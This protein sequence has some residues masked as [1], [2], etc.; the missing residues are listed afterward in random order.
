MKK[1]LY[2]ACVF[3]TGILVSCNKSE[4]G[5]SDAS[6]NKTITLKVIA[7]GGVQTRSGTS[8]DRFVIEVYSDNTYT[9]AANAFS[10]GTNKATNAT[11]EFSVILDLSKDYYCL[12]WADKNAST[13]YTVTDLKAV[14]VK[15]G[16]V[17]TEAWHG[18]LKI[19]AGTT[20]VQPVGLKRAV[21]KLTLWE[22]GMIPSG[23]GLKM[24]YKRPATFNVATAITSGSEVITPQFSLAEGVNG[25]KETPANINPEPVY[26]FASTETADVAD[27]TFTMSTDGVGEESFDVT[28]VPLQANYATHIKGHYTSMKGT[29]FTVTCD[30]Q[31]ESTDNDVTM[32]EPFVYTNDTKA[33]AAEGSGTKENPYLIA[34]AANV[35]WMQ[36]LTARN[37]TVNKYFKLTT[38]IEV[39]A[40]SWKPIGSGDY[41]HFYGHFDGNGHQFTGKLVSAADHGEYSYGIFGRVASPGSIQNLTNAAEVLAPDV[42]NVG[43]ITGSTTGGEQPVMITNCINTAKITGKYN[44]GGIVGSYYYANDEITSGEHLIMSDCENSGEIIARAFDIAGPHENYS[45]TGGI[46]GTLYLQP[47]MGVTN[48]QVTYILQN[49]RNK[50][51]VSA[52]ENGR[53]VGGIAGCPR[54]T[55]GTLKVKGC[56]NSGTVKINNTIA[57]ENLGTGENKLGLLVGGI[58]TGYPG[59]TTVEN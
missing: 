38:D 35:K 39:T 8:A 12:L 28:N 42:I 46:A 9:T 17:A 23:S 3:L 4:F 53:Y 34:S 32:V 27:F 25:T 44:V 24:A 26:I 13:A 47:G 56:I 52:P 30:G 31:W 41:I 7:D 15:S 20:E 5:G 6:G 58:Y 1:Y 18:T 55:D 40:D 33:K 49:C 10:D 14:G 2:I 45:S 19:D 22:T 48:D 11:G 51:N 43:G 54:I 29:T 50:G 37:A 21:A 36:G 16:S 57:T 59:I